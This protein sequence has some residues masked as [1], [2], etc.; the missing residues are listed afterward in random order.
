MSEAHNPEMKAVEAALSALT[1]RAER[2]DR[3]QVMYRAGQSSVRPGWTWPIAASLSLITLTALATYDLLKPRAQSVERVVYVRV[4]EQV[5]LLPDTA[6][7]QITAD[8]GSYL[9]LR[10][11]V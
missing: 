4:P 2:L 8:G 3:D 9:Q 11:R 1:P 10:D 6:A 5:Y 7:Q